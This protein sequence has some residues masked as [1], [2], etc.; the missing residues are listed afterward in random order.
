MSTRTD[1]PPLTPAASHNGN[2]TAQPRVMLQAIAAPSILGLFAFAGSTFIVASNLAGWYGTPDSPLVLAPFAAVFGGVAQLLAGMWSYR[3]RDGIATAA[4][5]AWGSF[6]IA[7]GI[8]WLLMATGTVATPQPWYNA[9]ELGWWFFALAIIT[10][11]CAIAA[12]FEGVVLFGVLATLTIGSAI[13]AWGLTDAS[14]NSVKVAGWVLVVSAAL[15][16]YTATALMLV[17]VTGREI[18]P[19]LKRAPATRPSAMHVAEVDVPWAE[20]GIKHGQ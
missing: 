17:G 2:G 18:L 6:W 15:A 7:Y 5:G 14:L 4:H 8:L 9:P 16:W 10:F 12:L 3:A 20:P 19:L 11:S 13:L 1:S